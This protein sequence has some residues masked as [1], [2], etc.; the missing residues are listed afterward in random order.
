MDGFRVAPFRKDLQMMCCQ[1]VTDLE[2]NC[3]HEQLPTEGPG[4]KREQGWWYAYPNTVVLSMLHCGEVVV[5]KHATHTNSC[6]CI[7]G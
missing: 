2:T 6:W 1:N 7:D 4:D 3:P 5:G